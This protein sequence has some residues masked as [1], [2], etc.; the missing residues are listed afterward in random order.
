MLIV[1]CLRHREGFLRV[2]IALA[3][4]TYWLRV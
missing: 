3:V 4:L 2:L 1:A